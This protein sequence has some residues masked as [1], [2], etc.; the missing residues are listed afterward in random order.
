MCTKSCLYF[1]LSV[2]VIIYLFDRILSVGIVLGTFYLLPRGF[3]VFFIK[4]K[5]SSRKN[6][7]GRG[8]R[9]AV[10]RGVCTNFIF[11][12]G[13]QKIFRFF[14]QNSMGGG[15]TRLKTLRVR[16]L[17]S[18]SRNYIYKILGQIWMYHLRYWENVGNKYRVKSKNQNL[19]AYKEGKVKLT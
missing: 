15:L 6:P 5:G 16:T 8:S 4:Y 7:G 19:W 17:V 14:L 18:F 13:V 3:G 1:L 10:F 12:R 9:P 2:I 11:F